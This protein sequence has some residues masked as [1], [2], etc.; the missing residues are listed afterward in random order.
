MINLFKKKSKPEVMQ[1]VPRH[2][3]IIMDGNGRWAK[4]R[5]L[6]R[7]A[8]HLA[9]K[10]RV[11][12]AVEVCLELGIKYLT[13]YAF[14]TENWRRP[15]EEVNYLMNLFHESMAQEIPKLHRNG[16]RV[17]FLGLKEGLDASLVAK[18]A[19]NEKLTAGNERLNLNLAINYGGRAEL[20]IAIKKI[21]EQVQ[22]GAVTIEQL[23]EAELN[24]YLFTAGQPDP[25]LLIK[26]GGE[27]RISNFLIWQMAY[28]EFYFST[29]LWPDFGSNEMQK[30]IAW[31]SQRERRFGS[32]KGV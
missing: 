7:G 25:D 4:Q 10:E 14:S 15:P 12:D 27:F 18:M 6:P 5:G 16:V 9:G 24:K 8:G 1:K 29:V 19:E 21:S 23:D 26:P 3:A 22:A 32:V 20:L 17:R 30:A 2:V 28:T 13:L 31:Y 11:N